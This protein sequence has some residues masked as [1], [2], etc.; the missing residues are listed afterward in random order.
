[1]VIHALQNSLQNATLTMA[2]VEATSKL[3]GSIGPFSYTHDSDA[4]GQ[5]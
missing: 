4:Q 1:M 2:L 5:V 3:E